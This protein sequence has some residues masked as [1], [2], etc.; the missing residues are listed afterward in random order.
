M[1]ACSIA[2]GGHVS[3]VIDTD[4][5]LWMWGCARNMQ[6]PH[7]IAHP[8]GCDAYICRE[9]TLVKTA[10]CHV[11]HVDSIS[12]SFDHCIC[13]ASDQRVYTWGQNFFGKLGNGLEKARAMPMPV[14]LGK[15][16]HACPTVAKVSA[17][18]F[19]SLLLAGDGHLWAAGA[20]HLG[21]GMTNGHVENFRVF[22][23]V[24]LANHAGQPVSVLDIAAGRTHSALITTEHRV[25][26][27]GRIRHAMT[28]TLADI[29]ENPS[30]RL[31]IRYGSGG[32]GYYHGLA[33]G[34]FVTRFIEVRQLGNNMGFYP[35]FS[36]RTLANIELFL[37][38]IYADHR[39]VHI[40]GRVF[41]PDRIFMNL[42]AS[43]L[44]DNIVL[45]LRSW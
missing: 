29:Q 19:H 30:L 26:T 16:P 23:K 41:Q 25:M 38:G 21:V 9:P 36:P 6:L 45:L 31:H 5:Q 28:A 27:C 18:G 8:T 22:R 35:H 20:C 33:V 39:A 4:R 34:G 13:V 43:E 40:R 15:L 37:L 44:I 42:L 10:S 17:G 7:R 3:S 2:C 24:C 14:V 12:I 1:S 32:L 11:L